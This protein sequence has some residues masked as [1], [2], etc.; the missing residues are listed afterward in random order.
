M[1]GFRKGLVWGSEGIKFYDYSWFEEAEYK[2]WSGVELCV[3]VDAEDRLLTVTT[4]SRV[5]RSYYDLVQQ[6]NTVSALRRRFGGS[7][8]TDEGSGRYLRPAH[9][10]PEPA[11]SGCHLA[12]WRFGTNAIKVLG[13]LQ[14]VQFQGEINDKANLP[15]FVVEM[16]PR[17]LSNNMVIACLISVVE[18]YL[19]S[20]FIALLKYSESRG[21]FFRNVRLQGDQLA[22]IAS[23]E[24]SVEALVAETLSFQKI[25]SACKHFKSLDKD[26]DLASVLRRPYRGRRKSL[27]EMLDELVAVRHDFVHRAILDHSYSHESLMQIVFDLDVAM[28]RIDKAIFVRYHWPIIGK[29]WSIGRRPN[30]RGGLNE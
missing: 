22:R 20:V 10:P 27:F 14:A 13:Y 6:N 3:Y 18:D 24:V 4:R 15:H 16:S 1:L 5:S 7:F 2:S 17:A 8:E 12:F 26:L 28:T 9:G 23:K 19:K 21:T 11:A 29:K 30:R 25:S